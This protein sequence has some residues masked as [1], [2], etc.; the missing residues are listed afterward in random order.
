M[1]FCCFFITIE[2]NQKQDEHEYK[3]LFFLKEVDEYKI[4][5]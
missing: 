2:I 1:H 4:L 5:G 3:I